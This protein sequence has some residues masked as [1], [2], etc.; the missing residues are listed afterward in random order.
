MFGHMGQC[1]V[2]IFVAIR[3]PVF[4]T[5]KKVFL[6]EEENAPSKFYSH[7]PLKLSI[8]LNIRVS[9]LPLVTKQKLRI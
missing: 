5:Q 3:Q 4:N 7:F 6:K 2:S 9:L 8:P 1:V